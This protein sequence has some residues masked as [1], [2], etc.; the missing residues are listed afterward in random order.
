MKDAKDKNLQ[1]QKI[2]SFKNVVETDPKDNK[3]KYSVTVNFVDKDNEKS[4]YKFQKK[5]G[6]DGKTKVYNL[7]PEDEWDRFDQRGNRRLLDYF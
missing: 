7:P 1:P 3:K 6:E 5:E 2:I 4:H